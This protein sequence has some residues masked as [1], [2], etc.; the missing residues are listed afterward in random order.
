MKTRIVQTIE[1]GGNT[2]GQVSNPNDLML[3]Q[4]FL[5][6]RISNLTR[7]FLNNTK[8]HEV[9]GFAYSLG[10]GNA[11]NIIVAAPGRIYAANG[12]GYDL[13]AGATL[14]VA[15]AHST[16]SRIDMVVAVLED[17]VD[18]AVALKPFVRLRTN[19]ELA[20]GAPP[21]APTNFSSAAEKHSRVTLQI[22]TGTPGATP[23]LPTTNANEVP[24]YLISVAPGAT[25]LQETDVLD[26]R[27]AV[28]T[29][30]KLNELADE[31]KIA[32]K[33]LINRV[34]GLFPL[35]NQPIDLVH[36]FG[37]I[38]SLGD[39]LTALYNQVN[40]LRDLPEIRYAN[41]KY[42]LTDPRTLKI[43]AA[44]NLDGST[45]VVDIEVGGVV[46]FS[47]SDVV[48][49]PEKFADAALNA[50]FEKASGNSET[51]K[52]ETALTINNIEQIT[53][54]GFTD[55][56]EAAAEFGS[57]KSRPA[58]AAR[59]EQFIEVFGGLA[60]N[61]STALGDWATYD[62]VNDTLTPRTPSAALP[63]ANRA[64][65]FSCGDGTNVLLIAGNDS[66]SAPQCFKINAAT[67]V[68]TQINTTKPTGSYFFGDLIASG[69]I[70]IVAVN[71]DTNT[72]QFWEYDTATNL[73]AQIGTTGSVPALQV[74]FA[75]G[76]FYQE[77]KFLLV[78]FTPGVTGSGKTFIFDRATSVWTELNIPGP[79]AN[80]LARQTP[81][82][83]FR[84]AN[85]NGRP[86]LVGG[87][88]T[89]ETDETKARIWEFQTSASLFSSTDRRWV[90]WNATSPPVQSIG[91]CSTLVAGRAT[92]QSALFAGQDKF[93]AVKREIFTSVQG[94]II[95]TTHNGA[96]A[97]TLAETST[98]AQFVVPT[99]AAPWAV[100]AYLLSIVGDFT[101]SNLK[102]EA[103]FD[104][105]NFHQITP[106]MTTL[107]EDSDSPGVRSL[108]I[109]FYNL[110]SSKPVLSELVEIFD[111][112]GSEVE[113]RLVIRYDA[114]NSAK[115][116][117]IDR[118]G[119]ITLS[120]TI[121]PS[122][123]DKA[124]L[125]KI[126]P[127][128]ALAPAV[129]NYINRRRPHVKYSKVKA[130]GGGAAAS[131]QFDNELA[132]PIRFVDARAFKADKT[133]YKLPD[134][135]VA[136]DAVVSV[137]DVATV[138]DTW[139]VELEG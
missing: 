15:A 49:R 114:P 18:A 17:D 7:D 59:N 87:L 63:N 1:N 92:G 91:F 108:R 51:E 62:V 43:S 55:F 109:T 66:N 37:Q 133:L 126:T 128:G 94:G 85:V 25:Q 39:I 107:I 76:C 77:N 96:A 34:D 123:P 6:T 84:L 119:I 48:L 44:G 86:L 42:A 35:A 74:D 81:L 99:R 113:S 101:E 52:I 82:S 30:Q 89:K 64:A 22:K 104:G 117:Y 20:A 47:G 12:K 10:A 19:D 31:N 131:I 127:N 53:A 72:T 93:N 71:P 26:A 8:P 88:L 111:E 73:F 56:N 9:V 3:A 21:Y 130:S 134:P 139:I 32:V 14:P 33:N 122:T 138:G 4:E 83:R 67:G 120:A 38:R 45:P 60:A 40:S 57:A 95:A 36:V 54:D 97:I 132:A 110:K 100:A 79:Y 78:K 75:H 80:T 137:A 121:E 16:L 41:P 129:K 70:F 61:N 124:I 69:K 46:N 105:E 23:S 58:C 98:F 24:L 115:A 27:E 112:D 125:H 135:T 136:F 28:L 13:L 11:F 65:M 103:T 2:Y 116:L 50:R 29:L 118:N 5:N 102:V 90:S 106:D 68:V